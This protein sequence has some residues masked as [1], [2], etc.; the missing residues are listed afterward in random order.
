MRTDSSAVSGVRQNPTIPSSILLLQNYPNPFNPTT[1]IVYRVTNRGSVRL[2]EP[3]ARRVE[4]KVYDVLGREVATP[5][6]EEKAPG[7]YG[8]TFDGSGVASGVYFY[9]LRAGAHVQS[10]KM[11]LVR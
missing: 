6:N 1:E 11:M 2:G 8:V 3:L 7:T 5:V 10:R 4:L 9:R